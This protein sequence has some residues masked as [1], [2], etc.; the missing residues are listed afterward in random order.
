MMP[1]SHLILGPPG[2]GKTTTLLDILES[3]LSAGVKPEEILFASFTRKASNEARDRALN[4]FPRLSAK[5]FKWFRTLH[6]VA[7]RCLGLRNEDIFNLGHCIELGKML[8]VY[9]RMSNWN[10]QEEAGGSSSFTKGTRM[11]AIDNLARVSETSLRQAWEITGD[12]DVPFDE[13][14]RFSQ[15]LYDFK[16][17]Q[18]LLDFTDMLHEFTYRGRYLPPIKAVILDE[19]QDLTKLHWSM[20]RKLSKKAER[21]YIAGDD[22][23]SIYEWS[24]A[25]IKTFLSLNTDERSVL[26]TSH[27]LP[28]KI[29]DLGNR[30]SDRINS[31]YPKKW[32]PR[33]PGGTV[34]Y[35]PDIQDIPLDKGNW[36]ILTRNRAFQEEVTDHLFSNAYP[37]TAQGGKTPM[38]PEAIKAIKSWV[39]LTD[40][41]KV[42][43]S[44]A[45]T[46]YEFLRVASGFRRGFSMPEVKDSDLYSYDMLQEGYGLVAD[47]NETWDKVLLKFNT[48]ER[49]FLL[50]V[51]GTKGEL[52]DP[53]IHVSTIHSIKGGEADNVLLLPDITHRTSMGFD[54][55]PDAEHRVWY[56][57]VTRAKE[58]LY[59]L[60]HG[61]TG[62]TYPVWE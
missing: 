3:E 34:E 43:G 22:D 60:T 27:R 16:Q 54:E 53:R 2:T 8:G 11:M 42:T 40:G 35:T 17:N 37:F 4:R 23:Q 13:M 29:F 15:T 39:V 41:G 31:R 28:Q 5:E 62:K 56:V 20:A 6:S 49:E 38:S 32:N 21:V 33:G 12:Q 57:G 45:K 52:E 46:M 10:E 61:T 48:K 14:E 47:R 18:G 1:N 7:Y 19:A 26:G 30:I 51:A 9:I 58:R 44:A 55:N 36:L 50:D 24:G 59:V 25:D